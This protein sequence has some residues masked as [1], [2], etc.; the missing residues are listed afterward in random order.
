MLPW[1]CATALFLGMLSCRPAFYDSGS[2]LVSNS[3]ILCDLESLFEI[4]VRKR[5]FT[6]YERLFSRLFH[7][8]RYNTVYLTCSKKLMD[9]QLS[10]PHFPA[11]KGKRA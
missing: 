2:I 1:K 5:T 10:L 3:Y 4:S 9:S 6:I 11:L 8:I 7:M